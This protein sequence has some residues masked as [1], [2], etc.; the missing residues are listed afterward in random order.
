MI[1]KKR[2]LLFEMFNCF[3]EQIR[4]FTSRIDT[5]YEGKKQVT[6]YGANEKA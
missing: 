3:E 6:M 4:F 5:Y 2:I 1:V